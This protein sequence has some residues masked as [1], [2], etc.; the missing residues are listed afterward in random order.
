MVLCSARAAVSYS[1]DRVAVLVAKMS[2]MCP[3]DYDRF[4]KDVPI[5]KAPHSS[6]FPTLSTSD[7]SLLDTSRGFNHVETH[8][9]CQNI[10]SLL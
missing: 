7:L 5:A 6:V 9:L 3:F 1:G 4:F 2:E 10:V 8:V